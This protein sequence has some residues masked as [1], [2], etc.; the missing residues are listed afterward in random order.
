MQRANIP[1]TT[2]DPSQQVDVSVSGEEI[3]I[4]NPT[5][6]GDRSVSVKRPVRFGLLQGQVRIADDF[7]APLPDDLL[8]A[9][10]GR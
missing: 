5:A 2:A 10:E 7:D 1:G 9:F 4:S 3:A 8:A 6:S